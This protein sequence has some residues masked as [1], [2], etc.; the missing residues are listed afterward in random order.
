M[1]RAAN[2]SSTSVFV[3]GNVFVDPYLTPRLPR[4]PYVLA[5]QLLE[6]MT[7]LSTVI[8][9]FLLLAMAGL[10]S[11]EDEPVS[12]S[13]IALLLLLLLLLFLCFT[14]WDVWMLEAF[15]NYEFAGHLSQ[16]KCWRP[17]PD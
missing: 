7:K 12:E 9:L 4:H 14:F 3:P 17:I 2:Y 16:R 6:K 10:A 1:S 5:R 8:R 11:T 15:S 13:I